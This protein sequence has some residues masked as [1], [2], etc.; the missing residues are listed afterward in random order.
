M[1]VGMSKRALSQISN[2][3]PDELPCHIP[4]RSCHFALRFRFL[5]FKAIPYC[6][7]RYLILSYSSS[8]LDTS[9]FYT[10]FRVSFAS[11]IINSIVHDTMKSIIEI[12]I[13]LALSEGEEVADTRGRIFAHVRRI[14]AMT[15]C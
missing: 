15:R 11:R 7:A 9:S 6:L 3:L 2:S 13:Y 14:L 4:L 12:E 5:A 1:G 10:F 8:L